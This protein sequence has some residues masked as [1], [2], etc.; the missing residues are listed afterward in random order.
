MFKYCCETMRLIEH[1]VEMLAC[2]EPQIYSIFTYKH[3]MCE[4]AASALSRVVQILAAIMRKV[5]RFKNM[6]KYWAK[7]KFLLLHAS[8][9][10][11][12]IAPIRVLPAYS[13][14]LPK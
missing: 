6:L 11:K 5:T 10:Q 3:Q 7:S 12:I 9:Q 14:T 1:V 2:V 8:I 13:Q 4:K